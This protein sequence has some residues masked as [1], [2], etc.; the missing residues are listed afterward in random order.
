LPGHFAKV[1]DEHFKQDVFKDFGCI[2]VAGVGLTEKKDCSPLEGFT[3]KLDV[4]V[5]KEDLSFYGILRDKEYAGGKMG[6]VAGWLR[7][8][9]G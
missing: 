6:K 2:I 7:G 5:V 4:S 3:G 9:K 1:W 8:S